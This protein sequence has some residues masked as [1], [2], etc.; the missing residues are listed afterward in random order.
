[1]RILVNDEPVDVT[2]SNL[3]EILDH[4]GYQRNEIVVAHNS[5]FVSR[6]H[7]DEHTVKEH[8]TL[9]VLAAMFGG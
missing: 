2:T 3:G 8:D 5:E 1:M 4:L 6:T 7:W 9:D